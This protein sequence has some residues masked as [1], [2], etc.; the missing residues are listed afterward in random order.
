MDLI[1]TQFISLIRECYKLWLQCYIDCEVVNLMGEV[2]WITCCFRVMLVRN[3]SYGY[4]WFVWF[5]Y[6]QMVLMTA[7]MFVFEKI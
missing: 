3:K 2:G 5:D 7:P 6:K 1:Q 4:N